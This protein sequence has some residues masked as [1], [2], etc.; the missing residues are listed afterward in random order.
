MFAGSWILHIHLTDSRENV[1]DA[2][3]FQRKFIKNLREVEDGFEEWI[4]MHEAVLAER[5]CFINFCTDESRIL[6]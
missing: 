3:N 6:C 5:V 2:S 4:L 1:F